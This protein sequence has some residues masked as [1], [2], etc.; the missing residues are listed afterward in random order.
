MMNEIN[1]IMNECFDE[2]CC[3]CV[4]DVKFMFNVYK[5]DMKYEKMND[6]ELFDVMKKC[7]NDDVLY[8]IDESLMII[9]II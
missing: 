9:K 4:N 3:V 8:D 2:N 1:E 5:V 6:N 7:L